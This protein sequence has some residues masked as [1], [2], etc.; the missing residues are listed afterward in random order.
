M[1]CPHYFEPQLCPSKKHQLKP[2]PCPWGRDWWGRSAD[3]TSWRVDGF[4]KVSLQVISPQPATLPNLLLWLWL[5][6]APLLA[7]LHSCFAFW[8]PALLKPPIL[9]GETTSL[10]YHSPTSTPSLNR[11]HKRRKA[12]A[13]LCEL[14]LEIVQ[15]YTIFALGC[16]SAQITIRLAIVPLLTSTTSFSLFCCS[17]AVLLMEKWDLSHCV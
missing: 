15:L 12:S 10:D 7:L 3:K 4:G 2:L 8:I 5:C 9:S 16:I 17:L 13:G 11:C 1:G 6:W 14:A